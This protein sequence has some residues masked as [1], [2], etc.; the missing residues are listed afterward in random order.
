[1]NEELQQQV[2][3]I[4]KKYLAQGAFTD[5]KVTDLPTDALQVVPRKYVTRNFTTALRPTTSIIGEFY[6]DTTIHKPVW[7]S[8]SNYRDAAGNII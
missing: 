3:Q 2:I 5:R 4:I 7:W 1:M 8:G 6:Y